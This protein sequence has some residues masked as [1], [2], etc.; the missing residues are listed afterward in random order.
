ML[1]HFVTLKA[2][3]NIFIIVNWV[4]GGNK[5]ER[6]KKAGENKTQ[7]PRREMS[8]PTWD[9]NMFQKHCKWKS[10]SS[11]HCSLDCKSLW[12]SHLN[13]SYKWDIIS[14]YGMPVKLTRSQTLSDKSSSWNCHADYV[15]EWLSTGCCLSRNVAILSQKH[16]CYQLGSSVSLFY[17]LVEFKYYFEQHKQ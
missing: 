16:Y 6:R 15:K 12:C 14:Y 17:L 10:D 1:S 4:T 2:L 7:A 9:W 11:T 3:R 8:R 13:K 5:T